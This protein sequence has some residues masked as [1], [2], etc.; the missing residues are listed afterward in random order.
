MRPDQCLPVKK[1]RP[2]SQTLNGDACEICRKRILEQRA[3]LP[4]HCCPTNWTTSRPPTPTSV[5]LIGRNFPW[6]SCD[7]LGMML[8]A[9]EA[10][11]RGM[12]ASADTVDEEEGDGTSMMQLAA[13]KASNMERHHNALKSFIRSLQ[14]QLEQRGPNTGV[15][16]RMLR[17]L[18]SRY[19][20][21]IYQSWRETTQSLY[22]LLVAASQD[23]QGSDDILTTED[24]DFLKQW[25]GKRMYCCS[26]WTP[27]TTP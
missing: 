2:P 26:A 15:A 1:R 3:K 5:M 16:S 22:F 7:L 10:A 19:L 8:Q 20:G 6:T 14:V 13:L 24:E 25:G 4:M 17:F 9:A 11:E 23:E 27:W 12:P 21:L 18:R